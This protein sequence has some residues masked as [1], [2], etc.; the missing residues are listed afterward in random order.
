M[1]KK[2]VCTLLLLLGFGAIYWVNNPVSTHNTVAWY[3]LVDDKQT[4]Y[5]VEFVS[6]E[7]DVEDET[8]HCPIPMKD[9]VKNYTG[10]QCVWSSIEA[11]GRWAEEPKLINPPLTSHRDCKSGAGPGSAAAKLREL[12]VKFEQTSGDRRAGIALI[13]KAMAEGRACLFDVP[14]HAM[15]LIH[16]DEEANVVKW[17]NNSDSSLK[18]QTMTIEKFMQRWDNWVLVIYADNDIIP[19]KIGMIRGGVNVFPVVDPSRPDI[20]I[21]PEFVPFKAM[22]K[23]KKAA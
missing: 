9:R 1:F 14:G 13:K 17:F 3:E 16:Y 12:G 20:K 2:A 11:L 18:I 21:A 5:Q 8:I 22:L 19:Q 15:V 4:V 23:T 10:I 7:G 6:P